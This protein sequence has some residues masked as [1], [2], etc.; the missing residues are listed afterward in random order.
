M[1]VKTMTGS[2]WRDRDDNLYIETNI[3]TVHRLVVTR[4]EEIYFED[5][6]LFVIRKPEGMALW[7]IGNDAMLYN[8]I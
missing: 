8:T 5:F 7:T 1:N 6:R 3:K 2:L 4:A